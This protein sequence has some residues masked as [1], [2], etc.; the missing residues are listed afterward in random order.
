[1]HKWF[2]PTVCPGPY[3]ESKFPHIAS[4]VNKRLTSAET[5]LKPA[6]GVGYS[7]GELVS[8]YGGKHY[9]S[10]N[11]SKGFTVKACRAKVTAVYPGGK[12]PIHLRAVDSKGNFTPGVYG[13]VDLNTI[14]SQ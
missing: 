2:T 4:E 3:L 12:H 5:T 14:E 9:A 10:T 8:F 1:M 11:S 13:W 7:V 6:N